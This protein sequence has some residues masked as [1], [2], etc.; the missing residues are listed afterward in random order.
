MWF[1]ER[2]DRQAIGAES[3]RYN[4]SPGSIITHKITRYIREYFIFE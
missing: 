3:Q 4:I 2:G 1:G